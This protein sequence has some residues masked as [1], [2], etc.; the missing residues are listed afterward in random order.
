MQ[1]ELQQAVLQLPNGLL[2][3][4]MSGCHEPLQNQ[5][6]ISPPKLETVS[7]GDSCAV[8]AVQ[9]RVS[10]SVDT[11]NQVT[12]FGQS[13]KAISHNQ[14]SRPSPLDVAQSMPSVAKL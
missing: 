5:R 6:Q 13:S 3:I 4:K 9:D 2:S 8:T 12:V 11:N 14:V 10:D 7:S 1:W